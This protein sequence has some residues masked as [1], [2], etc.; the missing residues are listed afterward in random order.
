MPL[1]VH[2]PLQ[3]TPGEK[4]AYT[5]TNYALLAR[6]VERLTGKPLEALLQERLFAPLQMRETFFASAA[7]PCATNYSAAPGSGVS[8]R[9]LDF[10]P[11]VHAAGGLCSSVGDLVRWNL[12]LDAGKV[13]SPE[14]ARALWTATRLRN[15]SPARLDGRTIGYG[16]GW[17]VDDTPGRRSVG[18]SGG[19]STAYR[20]YRDPHL[21]IIVLHNGVLDP[22]G[23]VSSIATIVREDRAGIAT[24]PQEKFWDAS[25]SGDT[26]A[27][28]E[29]LAAGADIEALDTRRS[30]N[31]RRAL[32]WAAS[33]DHADAVRRLLQRGA[34]IDA[35]N[36]S[37]F[38]ALHHAAESGSAAAAEALLTAGANPA[39]RN[40]SGELPA[41]VARRKGHAALA[42]RLETAGKSSAPAH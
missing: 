9:H 34:A 40:A 5:Q 23:V 1:I 39:L 16:L 28:E 21:T 27:I 18:H 26:K 19:N 7:R 20:R 3:F 38:T 36:K 24:A 35:A 31:G 14:L 29:S 37:A 41:D 4:W 2:V 10:P 13:L 12:A 25:I 17:V 8:V 6:I 30:S 32:N 15:G 11:F 33:G 22:D 42:K